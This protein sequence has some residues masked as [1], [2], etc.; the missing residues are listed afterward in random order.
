MKRILALLITLAL[1]LPLVACGGGGGTS[2]LT[3]ETDTLIRTTGETSTETG[4]GK[5]DPTGPAV[6]FGRA[7]VTPTAAVSLS[8]YGNEAVRLSKN[9]LDPLYLTCVALFDGE[10][11]C[12]FYQVDVAAASVELTDLVRRVANMVAQIPAEQV[13]VNASHSHSAPV[14][15]GDLGAFWLAQVSKGAQDAT[16]AAIADLDHVSSAEAGQADAENLNFT[17]RYYAEDGFVAPNYDSRTNGGAITAHE[18][19]ADPTIRWVRFKRDNQKDVVLTNWQCHATMTGGSKKYDVSADFVGQFRKYAEEAL[20]VYTV[21]FQGGAGN[22]APSSSIAGEAPYSSDYKKMGKA[23][24]DTMVNAWDSATP[25]R[26]GKLNFTSRTFAGK[27]NHSTDDLVEAAM[28]VQSFWQNTMD[29]ARTTEMAKPYG[30][31]S[32][33]EANAIVSRAKLGE[34]SDVGL[35]AFSF[36]D[37]ALVTAPL[38]MFSNT[39]EDLRARSP[40]AMTFFLGYT[41]G[42]IGYMPAATSFPNKG[43]E[44]VICR[45]VQ[46]T[47]EEIEEEQLS[48]LAE[49]KTQ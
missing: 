5:H 1:L 33:Y 16:R 41:N 27:V 20:D 35:Y 13:I 43:Y 12:L 15:S 44:V 10:T 18:F 7:D 14:S 32:P 47:T 19:K 40:Y 34:T 42:L 8:G 17:R 49:L 2:L 45:F 22:V 4:S 11:T 39:G 29:A 30:I 38:E 21:Y 48:M 46:G 24:V 28:K 36:G 6:G 37:F 26:L 31:S 25:I 3:E 23:L 9:I